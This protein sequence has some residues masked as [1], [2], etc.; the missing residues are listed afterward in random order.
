MGRCDHL[1]TA[2]FRGVHYFFNKKM[3]RSRIKA[4]FEFFNYDQ[5]RRIR[6]SE[7]GKQGQYAQSTGR[8]RKCYLPCGLLTMPVEAVLLLSLS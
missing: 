2:R 4:V 6:I 1:C 3:Y 8:K 7:D 5:R